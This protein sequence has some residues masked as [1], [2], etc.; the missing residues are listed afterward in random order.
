METGNWKLETRGTVTKRVEEGRT[1]GVEWKCL[2]NHFDRDLDGIFSKGPSGPSC[3]TRRK[4]PLVHDM[5]VNWT[6]LL[7]SVGLGRSADTVP[8]LDLGVAAPGEKAAD[9]P[10]KVWAD[11]VNPGVQL[12]LVQ[13]RSDRVLGNCQATEKGKRWKQAQTPYPLF[14]LFH[15]AYPPGWWAVSA[16]VNWPLG[17]TGPR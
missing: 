11:K 13:G 1:G 5:T 6:F 15:V 16:P 10:P 17:A 14:S 8:V 4:G 9:S 7:V 3:C 12:R 2:E